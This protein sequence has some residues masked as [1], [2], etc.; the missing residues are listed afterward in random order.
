VPNP[1]NVPLLLDTPFGDGKLLLRSIEGQEQISG[2]FRYTLK[3]ESQETALDFKKVVGKA[4]T[5]TLMLPGGEKVYRNGI[6][7][8]FTQ[9]GRNARG[10]TYYADLHP[11]LWLLTMNSDCRIFQN[12]SVPDILKAVFNDLGFQ[13]FQNSLKGT[14]KPREYCVQ[15]MESTFDFVSRL[16]EEEGIF[17]FF[18]HTSSGHKMVLADDA[19]AYVDCVG[20]TSASMGGSAAGWDSEAAVL[21]CTIEE[22]VVVGKYKTTDYNFET[23]STALVGTASGKDAKR[24]IYE[25]PGGHKTQS[26]GQAVAGRA[27]A[28]YEA[29]ARILRGASTCRSFGAGAK[30]K[31]EKHTRA[32]A[33]DKWVLKSVN[34]SADLE[35]A[36]TNSF[37]GFPASIVFRPPRVTHKPRIAGVQTATVT[38]KA[39]EEIFTDQYGRIK[40][41]FHWDQVG[42]NDENASCWIRVAHSWA[43]KQWGTFFLPRVGQEVVVTFLEGNPDRPL[44]TGSVYNA[45]QTVPYGLP[46]EQTKSTMKSRSSKNGTGFN[47]FRFEDK[48]DSE[49]IFLHAQKDL[50]IKVLNDETTTITNNRTATIQKKNDTLTVSEGDR[51]IKVSKGKETHDVKGTR[52]V[53]VT[54]DETHTDKANFTQKVTKNYTLK[55]DGN[56]EIEATGSV[57]IKAGK[58]LTTQAGTEVSNKAGTSLTNKAGT[59]LTNQA[60]TSLTNKAG[61]TLENNAGVSLTNK[62]SASQTVDGGGMLT[63]KGGMVKIN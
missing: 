38:G 12:K 16:M 43:G 13:D 3:A 39:G 5:V 24:S 26:D 59:A 29:P 23:P 61:T 27:L 28:A 10:T 55:V 34:W 7:G 22:N 4:A 45:T 47:E 56:I 48:K 8:R 46:A 62:G 19:S 54:G 57:T 18:T 49:E 1:K 6:V 15:Y 25:Y 51:I 37:E 60:G 35:A 50:Q 33:N 31:L 36:Y 17:Y 32:D 58:G 11:W 42:K 9:A 41:K 14:Y 52:E 21:D 2:L 40:V 44:V 20:I 63:I 30:F 53:T